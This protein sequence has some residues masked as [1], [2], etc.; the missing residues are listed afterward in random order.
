[1]SYQMKFLI[2]LALC[3][4]ATLAG[5]FWF[6]F[7]VSILKFY[8]KKLNLFLTVLFHHFSSPTIWRSVSVWILYLIIIIVA[9]RNNSLKYYLY[10]CY[11]SYDRNHNSLHSQSVAA[12]REGARLENFDDTQSAIL[13]SEELCGLCER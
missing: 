1:M 12:A 11:I 6:I 3:V 7:K 8:L 4:G 13:P 2:A 5:N 9:Y 10:Q